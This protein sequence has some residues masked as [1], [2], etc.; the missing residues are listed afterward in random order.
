[1]LNAL[2][3]LVVNRI[4]WW[5]MRSLP[6]WTV[7]SISIVFVQS[8]ADFMQAALVC[9]EVTPQSEIDLV[10]FHATHARRY[11]GAF[12]ASMLVALFANLYLGGS[13]N[14]VDYLT[15]NPVLRSQWSR[16]WSDGAGSISPRP[17]CSC[18]SGVTICPSSRSPSNSG[19]QV[20][21]CQSGTGLLAPRRPS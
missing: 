4:S 16:R 2:L 10:A 7:I 19:R 15:Q 17:S 1:M 11:I 5:Q 12:A 21:A 13:Y 14:I 9:P 6:S 3:L 8:F 20:I 18:A